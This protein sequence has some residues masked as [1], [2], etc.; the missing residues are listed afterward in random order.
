VAYPTYITE[1]LV[2]GST[3]SLGADRYFTL[4]TREAGMVQ[5]YAK[6]V[7]EERSK[8]RYALQD[9]SRIRVTLVRGKSGWRIAGTEPVKN[10]YACAETRQARAAL[11]NLIMLVR[12]LMHGESVQQRIFD[13]F[14]YACEMLS[15]HDARMLERVT[16]LRILHALGYVPP[17]EAYNQLLDDAFPTDLLSTCTTATVR[18]CDQA[19]HTALHESQL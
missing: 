4:L 17:H 18:A 2:C 9:C 14:V 5:A 12:R 10:Y 7:R 6:S 19:V 16:T 15:S 3:N 1:A 13:D 8:Q 11:R